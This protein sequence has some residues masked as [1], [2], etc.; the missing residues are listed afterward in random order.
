MIQ[1]LF[2]IFQDSTNSFEGQ[3]NDEKVVL[4]LRRHPFT[5]LIKIAFFVLAA[6]IPIILGA[7]FGQYLLA[8]HW[9]NLFLF[10]SSLWYLALWLAVFY[11][12]TIYL[13]NTVIITDKRLI[14]SE[15][16]GLFN[17]KISELHHY[18]VQDV[19]T[20]TN[21]LIETFLKFGDVTVQTAAAEQQFV[22]HQIPRPDKVKG[23]IMRTAHARRSGIK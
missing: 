19:S 12:L 16:L 14:E 1:S 6:L 21:G 5:I 7:I 17:R 4:L 3:D 23:V 18:R 8:S 2:D 15:Q 20:H 13:L 10:G 11:A 9:F 22:F